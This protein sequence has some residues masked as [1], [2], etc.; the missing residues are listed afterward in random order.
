MP[1]RSPKKRWKE[2]IKAASWFAVNPKRL[3]DRSREGFRS[4][5]ALPVTEDILES[6]ERPG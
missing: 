4:V 6:A 1:A 2:R 5:D 3:K